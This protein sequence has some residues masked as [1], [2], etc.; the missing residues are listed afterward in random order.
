MRIVYDREVVGIHISVVIILLCYLHTV[1][2]VWYLSRVEKDSEIERDGRI[3]AVTR[4]IP[5]EIRASTLCPAAPCGYKKGEKR[6]TMAIL[7]CTNFAVDQT[8]AC[9]SLVAE[10]FI[11]RCVEPAPRWNRRRTYCWLGRNLRSFGR[12]RVETREIKGQFLRH[13]SR[14]TS[15]FFHLGWFIVCFTFLVKFVQI[16]LDFD[17][18]GIQVLF[19]AMTSK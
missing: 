10:G 4:E 8:L 6:A 13:I 7:H 1:R 16:V 14:E 15:T 2:C 19:V 12:F 18:I 9:C 5:T 17:K 11:A 3:M